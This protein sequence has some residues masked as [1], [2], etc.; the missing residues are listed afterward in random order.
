VRVLNPGVLGNSSQ[1]L[2]QTQCV[3]WVI[4]TYL[5]T[6]A[7]TVPVLQLDDGTTIADILG[8]CRYLEELYPDPPLTHSRAESADRNAAMN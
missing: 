7:R 6:A 3:L 4:R 2:G 1:V 5:C 8:I